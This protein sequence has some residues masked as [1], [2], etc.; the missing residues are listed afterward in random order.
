MWIKTRDDINKI[1][2]DQKTDFYLNGL[3]LYKDDSLISKGFIQVKSV[4]LHF[5]DHSKEAIFHCIYFQKD[6]PPLKVPHIQIKWFAFDEETSFYDIDFSEMIDQ[7]NP[8]EKLKANKEVRIYEDKPFNK[9]VKTILKQVIKWRRDEL[10][11][12]IGWGL[13]F[14]NKKEPEYFFWGKLDEFTLTKQGKFIGKY[15]ILPRNNKE[16]FSFSELETLF[17]QI[18]PAVC[19]PLFL[20]VV[21]SMIDPQIFGV[22]YPLYIN[23]CG[24]YKRD[25]KRGMFLSPQFIANLLCNFDFN[26]TEN[27]QLHGIKRSAHNISVN[28]DSQT[29]HDKII[30]NQDFPVIVFGGKR[31]ISGSSKAYRQIEKYME[32]I[33]GRTNS[34]FTPF[35]ITEKPIQRDEIICLKISNAKKSVSVDTNETICRLHNF[36]EKLISDLYDFFT[37]FYITIKGFTRDHQIKMNELK[38]AQRD[39]LRPSVL[40]DD[41]RSNELDAFASAMAVLYAI[42]EYNNEY[43]HIDL[44]DEERENANNEFL[45]FAD[46]TLRWTCPLLQLPW[47]DNTPQQDTPSLFLE[48]V[49]NALKNNFADIP[50]FTNITE[51]MVFLAYPDCIKHFCEAKGF[52]DSRNEI[53]RFLKDH[54]YLKTNKNGYFVSKQ[55]AKVKHNVLAIKANMLEN[56]SI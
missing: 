51:D 12:H 47:I 21:Y 56:N 30:L 38:K 26:T 42:N 32:E 5:Y 18:D 15:S 48:Y 7:T 41:N 11:Q 14:H 50:Y 8:A 55:V 46:R 53:C 3:S 33:H 31:E 45:S 35:F 39:N 17:D 4:N 9:A 16:P 24:K 40:F 49:H 13:K 36:Y 19:Y 43:N 20:A 34:K 52:V 2:K 54:G 25:K 29:I 44:S 28:D 23:I 10:L 37:H 6:I 22:K 27:R 1:F